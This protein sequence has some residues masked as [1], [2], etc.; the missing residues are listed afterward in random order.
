MKELKERLDVLRLKCS[1][2]PD[3]PG[4]AQDAI[5]QASGGS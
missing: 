5:S 3:D 2:S 4:S 1:K